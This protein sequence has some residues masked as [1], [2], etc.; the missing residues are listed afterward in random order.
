MRER[1]TATE[2]P[3]EVTFGA[4]ATQ[5][6]IFDA[7]MMDLEKQKQAKEQ[8]KPAGVLNKGKGQQ[9]EDDDQQLT[10][11]ESKKDATS[12]SHR[13]NPLGYAGRRTLATKV[14][15]RSQSEVWA[16]QCCNGQGVPYPR[17]HG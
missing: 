4:T 8:K 10:A 9:E 1:S 16:W 2:P 7:Y 3:P 11:V 14:S 17:A 13:S 15:L 6:E 12:Q 5:W